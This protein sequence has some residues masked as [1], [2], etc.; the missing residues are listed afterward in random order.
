MSNTLRAATLVALVVVSAVVWV[1]YRTVERAQDSNQSVVHTQEVLA[2]LETVLSTLVDAESAAR[3]DLASAGAP[4]PLDRAERTID[5][6]V[7][8]LATLTRDNPTQQTNVQQLRQDATRT[9]AALRAQWDARRGARAASPADAETE[10]AS[11]DTARATLRAMRREENRLL[12][13]R[14]QA[15]QS[16]SSRLQLVTF[17]LVAVAVGLLG[18]ISWLFVRAA[19]RQRQDTDALRHARNDL[20]LQVDARS[21]DL[22]ESNERLRSIIDS[23]VDGIIVI[24]KKGTIEGFNRGAERLFGY[25]QSEVVGRNVSMLMPSPDHE[26]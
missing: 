15:D 21:A 19:R 16:A 23:A 12:A 17:G 25:P 10:R 14:V 9:L 13:N 26:Q 1:V 24:D 6:D 7:T 3:S 20:A 18:W 2:A 8:R 4:E 22:R 11:M 5:T